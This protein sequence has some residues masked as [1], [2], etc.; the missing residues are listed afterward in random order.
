MNELKQ[1][2]EAES[3]SPKVTPGKVLYDYRVPAD[4]RDDAFVSSEDSA[5]FAPH[6]HGHGETGAS[7][8]YSSAVASNT[9]VASNGQVYHVA[10]GLLPPPSQWGSKVY[11]NDG[12]SNKDSRGGGEELYLGNMGITPYRDDRERERDNNNHKVEESPIFRGSYNHPKIIKDG[13]VTSDMFS[14][15]D[16]SRS[17]SNTMEM[18]SDSS[19]FSNNNNSNNNTSPPS[20]AYGMGGKGA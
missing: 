9:I 20:H 19:S 12:G 17:R 4:Q 7:G 13:Q 2:T 14:L 3:G 16:F 1:E 10:P 15:R 6:G 8:E 18:N 11:R 5:L